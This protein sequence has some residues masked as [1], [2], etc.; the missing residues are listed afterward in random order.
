MAEILFVEDDD[1]VRELFAEALREAHFS[2]TE[3]RRAEDVLPELVRP[4]PDVVVLDLGMPPG[5]LSGTELL[6]RLRETP[7]WR[8]VPVI[9][10]SGFGDV[11]NPDVAVR[12]GVREI[13]TKGQITPREL[14][15][16]VRRAARRRARS[17]R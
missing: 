10:L 17:R 4:A 15:D 8:A 16:A 14:V 5:T 11:L 7:G 13:F 12:L 9:I 2:V 6:A 3:R 1:A